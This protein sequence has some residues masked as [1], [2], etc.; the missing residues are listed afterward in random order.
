MGDFI[1]NIKIS[2]AHS[3]NV[4]DHCH[5]LGIL[6]HFIV[7]HQICNLRGSF[8]SLL[9]GHDTL[10]KITLTRAIW[11]SLHSCD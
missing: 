6:S 7:D 5:T 4:L 8:P 3:G 2:L 10:G 11:Q 9:S 1:L